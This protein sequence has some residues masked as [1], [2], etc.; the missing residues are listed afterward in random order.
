MKIRFKT[1]M[2][3][4]GLAVKS[5][6][7]IDIRDKDALRLI[8]AGYAVMVP[9]DDTERAVAVDNAVESRPRRGRPRK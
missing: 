1:S 2:Q 6:D 5:G 3:G 4:P 7:E 9:V 8:K